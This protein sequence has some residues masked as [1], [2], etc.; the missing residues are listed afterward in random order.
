MGKEVIIPWGWNIFPLNYFNNVAKVLSLKDL[1]SFQQAIDMM[2][3]KYYSSTM[4]QRCFSH[5]LKFYV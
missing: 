1:R 4:V 5:R 3:V 2:Q